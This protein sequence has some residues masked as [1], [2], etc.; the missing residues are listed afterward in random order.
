[1]RADAQRNIGTYLRRPRRCSSAS[2]V[3]APVREIAT[4]AG[5]GIGTVYRHFPQR[6]DLIAA[7]FRS[8]IDA[9]AELAPILAAEHEAGE[10]LAKWCCD[11]PP[12]LQSNAGSPR[13]CT[14]E[15]RPSNPCAAYSSSASD[16][17]FGRFFSPR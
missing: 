17:P 13:P 16:P 3:D 7:V 1:M 8:E 2:G 6:S 9:C 11:T 5:V 12:L 4:Q 14:R 10:A 15:T